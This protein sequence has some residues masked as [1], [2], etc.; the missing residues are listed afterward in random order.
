MPEHLAAVGKF[1]KELQ[2][3]SMDDYHPFPEDRA[4]ASKRAQELLAL[5]PLF[6]DTETTGLD[7]NSEIVE[8]AILNAAGETVLD[9][10]VKP[11]RSI[12]ASAQEIHHITDEMVASAPTFQELMPEL[13]RI[14]RGREVLVYNAEFDE[15]MLTA[16]ARLNNCA[17]TEANPPWYWAFKVQ[18]KTE[19][20][21]AIYKSYWHCIMKLYAK[22][23]GDWNEWHGNYR[24]IPLARAARYC[25]I[26]M[27][28][29]IHR[30]RVD[31]ELARQIVKHMAEWQ[32]ETKQEVSD[33]EN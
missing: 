28:A 33:V 8:I 26:E 22:F 15:S 29:G 24:W 12:P 11:T 6:L 19:S 10:L 31:A 3:D 32:P 21:P 14:L 23:Y 30:A 16:S 5:D 4:K 7:G 13:E 9:T 27:P 25:E 1:A 2:G 17:F 20:Q 18:D